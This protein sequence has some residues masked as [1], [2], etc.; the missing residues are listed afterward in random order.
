MTQQQA[1]HP[2]IEA[3]L[4]APAPRLVYAVGGVAVMRRV[5]VNLAVG[6]LL[7][8]WWLAS[9]GHSP[10][11]RTF[12]AIC[13]AFCFAAG[14]GW[15]IAEAYWTQ[16]RRL[17][18]RGFPVPATVIKRREYDEI[19]RVAL[20]FC[21]PGTAAAV[22]REST[23]IVDGA[24]DWFDA[25]GLTVGATATALCDP[26]DPSAAAL[27]VRLREYFRVSPQRAVAPARRVS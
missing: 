24:L 10:G 15:A 27:Y 23:L 13:W 19:T 22:T 18:S 6:G 26:G 3:K 9:C 17:L 7:L 25:Q 16:Q 21:A 11:D 1:A 20:P 8:G 5:L 2:T 12:A 14:A 4:L